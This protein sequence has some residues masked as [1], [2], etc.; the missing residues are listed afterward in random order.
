MNV[1][2]SETQKP[3]LATIDCSLTLSAIGKTFRAVMIDGFT[4]PQ[5]QVQA[6]TDPPERIVKP[7]IVSHP[8]FPINLV[9]FFFSPPLPTIPETRFTCFQP[10]LI[11]SKCCT[12][13]GFHLSLFIIPFDSIN[14]R[15]TKRF[16]RVS[17]RDLGRE[18]RLVMTNFF[19]SNSPREVC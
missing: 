3:N 8:D 4:V 7:G 18:Y 17:I 15:K 13:T 6:N 10:V 5:V 1:K 16:L 14:R 19:Q 11:P 9:F 2:V 12:S